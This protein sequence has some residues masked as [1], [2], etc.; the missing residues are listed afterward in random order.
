M[1]QLMLQSGKCGWLLQTCD[2][3]W[4][5]ISELQFDLGLTNLSTG[6][7]KLKI[8]KHFSA[9]KAHFHKNCANSVTIENPVGFL[10][11]Q[12]SVLAFTRM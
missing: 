4:E 1:L 2:F 5:C 7:H 11:C 10:Q 12:C 9:K 3:S 6:A 8:W